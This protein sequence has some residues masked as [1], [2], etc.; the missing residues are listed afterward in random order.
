MGCC[1]DGGVRVFVPCCDDVRIEERPPVMGCCGAVSPTATG[2][3]A[4]GIAAML[5]WVFVLLF[6]V[7]VIGRGLLSAGRK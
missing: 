6:V 7:R 5:I 2:V 1:C 4:K 3:A